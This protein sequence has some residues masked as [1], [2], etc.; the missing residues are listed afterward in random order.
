M[1]HKPV[2][3][4]DQA[5]TRQLRFHSFILISLSAVIKRLDKLD[6]LYFCCHHLDHFDVFM[7]LSRARGNFWDQ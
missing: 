5:Q 6:R 3:V 1:I 4:P 2:E 7:P